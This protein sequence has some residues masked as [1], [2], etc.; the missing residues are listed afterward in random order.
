MKDRQDQ[1]FSPSRSGEAKGMK[2]EISR[3]V[4][5]PRALCLLITGI[6]LTGCGKGSSEQEGGLRGMVDA[7]ASGDAV[8]IYLETAEELPDNPSTIFG[9]V[10]YCQ[11]NSVFVTQLPPLDQIVEQGT[12]EKGPLVEV[13][14]V[15]DT[16][17]YKDVTNGSARNGVVK[18][19]VAPG[20]VDE[21]E[22]GNLIQVW[23][24]QRGDRIVADVLA[25]NNHSQLVLPS[26]PVN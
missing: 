10:D 1:T 8:I 22:G 25:Y 18:G 7:A 2:R 13:V 12:A 11:D 4:F 24:D 14:V 26:G 9:I 6:L 15:K 20:S 19:E 21:I 16:I 17:V 3:R 23:G 5:L